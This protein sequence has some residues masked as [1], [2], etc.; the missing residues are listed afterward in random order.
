MCAATPSGWTPHI[1]P[2]ARVP[3]DAQVDGPAAHGV[4]EPN[5][6]ARVDDRGAEPCGRVGRGLA[7]RDRRWA[8]V[9]P[10]EEPG[11]QVVVARGEVGRH[12][13][14][15]ASAGDHHVEEVRSST[16]GDVRRDRPAPAR[17]PPRPG[18]SLGSLELVHGPDL[19]VQLL[20]ERRAARRRQHRL[21]DRIGHLAERRHDPDA[22][23][24]GPALVA[25]EALDD[26]D[27]VVAD[28]QQVDRID[29]D[30]FRGC[31]VARVTTPSEKLR[32]ENSIR[33]GTE[34]WC[35]G[36]HRTGDEPAARSSIE[37]RRMSKRAPSATSASA[38]ATACA[39]SPTNDT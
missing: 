16:N 36:S 27:G 19:E 39:S 22:A 32:I 8:R 6:H 29:A 23:T 2:I 18:R 33:R 31:R 21:R 30:S 13:H 14:A 10:A 15:P 3:P 20:D 1:T 12:D 38:N 17:G 25:H 34:R 11:Q 4:C 26:A 7:A 28:R 9:G 37:L 24:L 5:R 35:S